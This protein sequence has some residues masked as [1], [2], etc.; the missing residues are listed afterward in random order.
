MQKK[1]EEKQPNMSKEEQIGFHKGSLQTLVG[2]RNELI[3]M[4]Q[5]TETLMQ[6]HI[7]ALQKLGVKI[8]A[9]EP[10]KKSQKDDTSINLEDNLS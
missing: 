7:Q 1:K 3:K 6:A 10:Q 4:I 2:E 8:Q 5:I 9:Q